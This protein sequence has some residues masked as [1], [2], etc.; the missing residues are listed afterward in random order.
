MPASARELYAKAQEWRETAADC[1]AA[2]NE[3]MAR[4]CRRE[5]VACEKAA[6][7]R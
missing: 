6:K 5:A 7:A 4:D 1:E 2:G 3:A